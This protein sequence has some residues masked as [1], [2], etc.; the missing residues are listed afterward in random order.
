LDV[1]ASPTITQLLK[2]EIITSSSESSGLD[3][4]RSPTSPES[5]LSDR[6]FDKEFDHR[7]TYMFFL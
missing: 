7:G 4:I 6:D 1:A 2:K 3:E 5:N